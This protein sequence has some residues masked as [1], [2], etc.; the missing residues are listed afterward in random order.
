MLANL[1][2]LFCLLL[3]L[4]LNHTNAAC[5]TN[6]EQGFLF[7]KQSLTREFSRALYHGAA[8]RNI[9]SC[10]SQG[11]LFDNIRHRGN[12]H[13]FSWHTFSRA[14]PILIGCC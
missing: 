3:V 8:T 11:Y 14:S 6:Q 5:L 12:I 13:V 10:V 1:K 2:S 9:F 4:Y 7:L